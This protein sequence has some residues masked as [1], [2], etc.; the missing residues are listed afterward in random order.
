[1]PIANPEK[2]RDYAIAGTALDVGVHDF[3]LD[4]M[5]SRFAWVVFTEKVLNATFF[6][7]DFGNC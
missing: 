2:V 6:A 7:D 1:M 4:A 3:G 5:W